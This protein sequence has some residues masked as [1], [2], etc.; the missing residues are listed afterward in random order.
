ME[1]TFSAGIVVF[2]ELSPGQRTYLLLHYTSGH[3]D[4]PKGRIEAG[5]TKQEAAHRELKEETGLT[6]EIIPGFQSSFAYFF[7]GYQTGELMRKTVYFFTGRAS[8]DEIQLSHEH[9]GYIWFEYREAIK[10]ITYPNAKKLLKEV[11]EFLA[12]QKA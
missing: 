12:Q 9:I 7:K 1:E 3:W 4:F 5:E 10:R 11:E 8:D 6:A 2:K